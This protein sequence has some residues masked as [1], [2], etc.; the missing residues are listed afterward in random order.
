MPPANAAGT[1]ELSAVPAETR[2]SSIGEL[3]GI[4]RATLPWQGIAIAGLLLAGQLPLLIKFFADL[5]SRPQY[6]FF[7]VALIAAGY[8]F[9]DR[10][11]ETPADGM[12][13][14]SRRVT[15]ALLVL[16][17]LILSGGLLYLR[18]MAPVS[19][20][21]LLAAAV[22][23]LG[24][25][26][27]ARAA[28]P[29]GVLLLVMIPPPAHMDDALASRLRVM[30]VHA[31]SRVLDLV[32]L[33]HLVTGTVIEI[34]GHRLLV[35][36]ACSGIN[37]LMSVIAFTLLY[38]IWQRRRPWTTGL[39]LAAAAAFVICANVVRI[40][41]GA[42]LVHFW[43]IDIL[44][45]TGH[46]LLGMLLFA[47]S[48]ALVISFDRFLLLLPKKGDIPNFVSPAAVPPT[49]GTG[50][51]PVRGAAHGRDA[52]FAGKVIWWIAA[53]A[54]AGLGV[55]MQARVGHAWPTSRLGDEA[56]FTLPTN[57]AGWERVQGEGTLNGRPET[58]GRKSHF[59]V[60]RSGGIKAAVAMD[61]PFIG[62]HDATICYASSGWAIAT[63][64]ELQ[65]PGRSQD[66]YVQ[67]S[68]SK[69]PLMQGQLLFGLF[70]EH[71]VSPAPDAPLSPDQGKVR[72]ALGLSRQKAL[73]SPSY[74]VQ[75]L[76]IGYEPLTPAQQASLRAL[77]LAAR[78][79]LSRQLVSQV[80]GAP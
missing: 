71:G 73:A 4:S 13:R 60:Y 63:R 54:F 40:T 27:L 25:S 6:Q 16:S 50:V 77:F 33:P 74:Q 59:W 62:F 31:S 49:G 32:S 23:W 57:L 69:A 70:D 61:Y 52:R 47:I 64:S 55:C 65:P 19:A 21:L 35:E 36:E 10:M 15:I 80:G 11:R 41:L 8:V 43:Q 51:P 72:F 34:P 67:I 38:G 66:E 75:T 2:R 22:W 79:D 46:E 48:L 76:A 9:W 26:R 29:A 78:S 37:S 20:W 17:W 5:W 45:G 56:T 53:I 42:I 44:A 3:L 14:G 30:A 12:T 68:M 58:D 28:L 1:L 39:L 18:W 24:G 7:P